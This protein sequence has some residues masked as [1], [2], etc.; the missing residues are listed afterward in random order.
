M[1]E[2]ENYDT[3]MEYFLHVT[4]LQILCSLGVL[5]IV[6]NKNK[7]FFSEILVNLKPLKKSCFFQLNIQKEG[8]FHQHY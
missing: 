1:L 8:K 7:Y 2:E 4:G 3:A 6:L 5:Q